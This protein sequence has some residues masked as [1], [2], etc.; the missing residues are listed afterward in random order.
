MDLGCEAWGMPVPH[1]VSVGSQ[2]AAT[3]VRLHGGASLACHDGC[4]LRWHR[5]VHVLCDG[6]ALMG[7]RVAGHHACQASISRDAVRRTAR[8]QGSTQ[9]WHHACSL[10]WQVSR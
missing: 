10:A 1:S 3:R 7:G 6:R 2:S 9:R 4:L 5:R 8:A